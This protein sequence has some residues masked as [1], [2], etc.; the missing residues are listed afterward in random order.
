MNQTHQRLTRLII[1]SRKAPR[2][3][4]PLPAPDLPHGFAT[5]LAARWSGTGKSHSLGNLWERMCWWGGAAAVAVC[6]AAQ[7]LQPQPVEPNAFDLLLATPAAGDLL[8]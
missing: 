3:A 6:V 5:R 2:A 7:V 1:L 4:H 8:F